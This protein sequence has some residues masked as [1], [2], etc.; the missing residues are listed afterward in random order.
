MTWFETL[1]PDLRARGGLRVVLQS[2]LRT[3]VLD[4]VVDYPGCPPDP[5]YGAGASGGDRTI[6]VTLG[7]H[8]R[9]FVGEFWEAGVCLGGYQSASLTDVAYLFERW[10]TACDSALRLFAGADTVVR[11]NSWAAAHELGSE[12]YVAFWWHRLLQ[13][14]PDSQAFQ[15]IEAASKVPVLRGLRPYTSHW[16]LHFSRSAGYPFSSD[17]PSITPLETGLYMVSGASG[18]LIDITGA[19]AAV[20]LTVNYLP[21]GT[22]PAVRGPWVT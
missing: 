19:E 15:L 1:Y 3:A 7:C 18:T 16:T 2:H 22:G 9:V 10:I 21:P 17:C 20:L 5:G 13:D 6:A 14:A 8:E 12:A 4:P 11:L